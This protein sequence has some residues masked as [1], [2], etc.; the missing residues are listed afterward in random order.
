MSGPPSQEPESKRCGVCGELRSAE[1][2][3]CHHCQKYDTPL[4]R[5]PI[6]GWIEKTALI[7]ILSVA[8]PVFAERYQQRAQ[9]HDQAKEMLRVYHAAELARQREY[10]QKIISILATFRTRYLRCPSDDPDT[11]ASYYT[12]IRQ[13]IIYDLWIL[14]WETP[15]IF[16]NADTEA[17]HASE[18]ASRAIENGGQCA[19][20]WDDEYAK[21][22]VG[23][24]VPKVITEPPPSGHH[25]F[26]TQVVEGFSCA[27]IEEH[28][29]EE[30]RI[31]NFCLNYLLCLANTRES[32]MRDDTIDSIRDE[33][34]T[35][36]AAYRLTTNLVPPPDTPKGMTTEH[37][38]DSCARTMAERASICGRSTRDFPYPEFRKQVRSAMGRTNHDICFR[39]E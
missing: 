15:H 26:V 36:E 23:P 17:I 2:A 3:Y 13:D 33:F 28:R 29:W 7:G 35:K 19:R 24:K 1:A 22:C 25:P 10:R 5:R 38:G 18:H 9:S 30:V 39:E 11:C 37:A 4:N 8:I 34:D 12:N 27:R 20:I 21:H 32:Q 6:A 14:D 31:G 16:S